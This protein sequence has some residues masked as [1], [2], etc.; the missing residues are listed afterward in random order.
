MYS[1]INTIQPS[2]S[3]Q[4]ALRLRFFP[5]FD[6]VVLVKTNFLEFS[7]VSNIKV[8][9]SSFNIF[10]TIIWIAPISLP[11]S[12]QSGLFILTKNL[13]YVLLR[14]DE[15]TDAIVAV[16]SGTLDRKLTKKCDSV[17]ASAHNNTVVIAAYDNVMD[18]IYFKDPTNPQHIETNVVFSKVISLFPLS[19]TN[20]ITFM[21]VRK[22]KTVNIQTS[23]MQSKILTDLIPLQFDTKTLE[24][25][26]GSSFVDISNLQDIDYVLLSKNKRDFIICTRKY[27]VVINTSNSKLFAA[28]EHREMEICAATTFNNHYLISNTKGD[29]FLLDVKM[30][31]Q[32]YSINL[33]FLGET[34]VVSSFVNFEDQKFF[35]ASSI[36]DDKIINIE[37]ELQSN[38][39]S[40]FI[41]ELASYRS[42]API[43]ELD[44]STSNKE[45]AT[46]LICLTKNNKESFISII[47]KGIQIEELAIIPLPKIT[48]I[49]PVRIADEILTVI[50]SSSFSLPLLVTQSSINSVKLDIDMNNP[51]VAFFRIGDTFCHIN[52]SQLSLYDSNLECFQSMPLDISLQAKHHNGQVVVFEANCNLSIVNFESSCLTTLLNANIRS[53]DFHLNFLF[54]CLWNQNSLQIFDSNANVTYPV[55]LP[56]SE[57]FV[58]ILCCSIG[59]QLLVVTSTTDGKLI[60]FDF[61]VNTFE[62]TVKKL[63]NISKTPIHLSV[64]SETALYVDTEVPVLF[65]LTDF[66]I[67]ALNAKELACVTLIDEFTGIFCLPEQLVLGKIGQN[68]SQNIVCHK[69]DYQVGTFAVVPEKNLIAFTAKIEE[70]NA[71]SLN[72]ID[73]SFN[74]VSSLNLHTMEEG[75]TC[76]I[77]LKNYLAVGTAIRTKSDTEP[78]TGRLLL[79]EIDQSNRL[80]V[81]DSFELE[82]PAYK[83]ACKDDMIALSISN[84]LYLFTFRE[85]KI[86]KLSSKSDFVAINEIRFGAKNIIVSDIFK[87]IRVLSFDEKRTKLV[88]N[89]KDFNSVWMNSFDEI[90]NCKFIAG[91]ID[92]NIYVLMKEQSATSDEE[93]FKLDR[94]GMFNLGER[95]NCIKKNFK[96]IEEQRLKEILGEHEGLC[97]VFF[98]TFEGGL[99]VIVQLNEKIFEFLS[100][101]QNEVKRRLSSLAGFDYNEWRST[102]DGFVIKE[103]KNFIDGMLMKYYLNLPD[104][105]QK[106]ILRVVDDPWKLKYDDLKY[107]LVGLLNLQ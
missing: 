89:S 19:D 41:T 29:L 85:G 76:Q 17:I 32:K 37:S 34:T 51:T 44:F 70:S 24:L 69:G 106:E 101:L 102:D 94:V 107:L 48:S 13:K 18:C 80:V 22:Y 98:A 14:Y 39:R 31:D 11:N 82:G 74:Q 50:S 4:Q 23:E 26:V 25:R 45:V 43:V 53:F 10:S 61:N 99:G 77:V 83:M 57:E 9:S 90:S 103:M 16:S 100:M 58:T 6:S 79:I 86:I 95:V 81:A 62:F 7:S 47:R 40:P 59:N 5:T 78:S 52:A 93:N 97:S 15:N 20:D 46:D 105:E 63:I 8:Q 65:K 33:E 54:Y 12:N 38:P 30:F 75:S 104:Y 35:L 55:E 49:F 88:E 84:T 21:A 96:V 28:T 27:F 1:F 66:S 2:L 73:M 3:T 56:L 92:S 68:S 36:S 67:N 60:V 64:A 71:S 72:L 91:D 42:L 87:S